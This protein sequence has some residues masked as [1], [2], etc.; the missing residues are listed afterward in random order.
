MS[1]VT[2]PSYRRERVLVRIA[3]AAVLAVVCVVA[4]RHWHH[5]DHTVAVWRGDAGWGS[6][7][8][9]DVRGSV[10]TALYVDL[11][12]QCP[13]QLPVQGY[14]GNATTPLVL[15]AGALRG[16]Q[17]RSYSRGGRGS[18][19]TV[20][21]VA[22]VLGDHPHGM[23]WGRVTTSEPLPGFA[24]PATRTCLVGPVRIAFSHRTDV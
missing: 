19:T 3:L 16:R 22:L 20:M 12:V 15:G 7:I 8:T 24:F 23:L 11:L 4:Y 14:W 2:A 18:A 1:A 13:G 17:I 5:D 10:V 9:L 6:A 21:N